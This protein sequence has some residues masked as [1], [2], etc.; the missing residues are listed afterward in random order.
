MVV[1][2]L[3]KNGF[4]I[5]HGVPRVLSVGV[6][7]NRIQ[8]IYERGR[9]PPAHATIDCEGRY[10]L[11]G[12]IDIHV[13]MRD[14]EQVAKE[15]YQS[16]TR[17]A[18][19]GGVTTVVD[20]PNSKP[21]VFDGKVLQRKIHRARELGIVNV[22][23]YA[24]IPER[25]QAIDSSMI[26]D[27]LGFKVY[28]HTP[29]A[30]VHYDSERIRACLKLAKIHER[31]LLF[32]PDL[33][34]DVSG[35][36]NAEEFMAAHDCNRETRAV[37]EFT[38][39]ARQTGGALHVC[40]ISCAATAEFVYSQKENL[41]IT[42]E[43]TPHHLFLNREMFDFTDGTA[44]MLPPLR[45]PYE[46]ERLWAQF[47]H[48][49]GVDIIGSDHAPHTMN[50]KL[51]PFLRSPSGIPGLE[52]S[53]PLLLTA[54]FEGRLSWDIYLRACCQRPAD[55]LGI[56]RKGLLERGFDA[57]IVVV[58]QEDYEIRGKEFFSKSKITPFEGRMVK[59]R[60]IMT[61][62]GGTIVY[63]EREFIVDPGTA[64]TVPVRKH[65]REEA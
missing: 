7:G 47:L 25:P 43:A 48:G 44:K 13:H 62:V 2:L 31:P 4:V 40:H 23:F 59:A 17:A 24:G 20:M 6:E 58:A 5:R 49:R 37:R 3:L 28:P 35:Y 18:A 42:G 60:P 15:D 30:E 65:L 45:S 11:P 38:D 27:I 55:I 51:S 10:I 32:H 57:D 54:V 29:L 21:P 36:R 53:L 41:R 63:R 64:G 46:A 12:M 33:P 14:L 19:A 52:T 34:P 50:E 22:G 9:E 16:G 39:A 8:G 61:I 1:D 56:R 26:A